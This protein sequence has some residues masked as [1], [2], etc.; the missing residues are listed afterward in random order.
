MTRRWALG[1][2]ALALGA[3]DARGFWGDRFLTDPSAPCGA[4]GECSACRSDGDCRDQ[5]PVCDRAAGRC[6]GCASNDECPSG[7][8]VPEVWPG[9]SLSPGSCAPI[10]R[11]CRVDPYGCGASRDGTLE[12]PYCEISEAVDGCSGAYLAVAAQ[13]AGLRYRTELTVTGKTLAVTSIGKGQPVLPAVTVR[14][15]GAM[16]L[17]S[18]VIVDHANTQGNVVTC[19]DGAKLRLRQVQARGGDVGVMV[20]SGCLELDLSRGLIEGNDLDGVSIATGMV[21][22]R[23]VNSIIARN[24]RNAQALAAG[25]SLGRGALG[26]FAFNTVV[27]NGVTQSGIAGGV[28]CQTPAQLTDSIIDGNAFS[29]QGRSQVDSSCTLLRVALGAE[30]SVR[31]GTL[32]GAVSLE[33]DYRLKDA[34]AC[35]IDKGQT[36]L[37]LAV[38]YFGGKRPQRSGFDVGAH[39]LP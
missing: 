20:D 14:G 13:A 38:D 23:I 24:G 15:N 26:T 19:R 34:S 29:T 12:R 1:L 10:A 8:C 30:G 28:V 6:R 36:D 2:T 25:V 27:G 16:L 35:C 18:N 33:T 9:D 37:G 32:P 31:P 21:R 11:V 22:Y 17:L 39:E 5:S 3:C 7:V 4:G